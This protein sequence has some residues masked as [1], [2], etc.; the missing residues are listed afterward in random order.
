MRTHLREL[1]EDAAEGIRERAERALSR[2]TGW[3]D[4]LGLIW[5]PA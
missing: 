2:L 4:G 3:T 1:L 5:K